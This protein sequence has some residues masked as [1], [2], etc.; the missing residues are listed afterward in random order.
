MRSRI[1]TLVATL[2]LGA[3]PA[4]A[5][6][7]TKGDWEIGGYGGY[8]WLNEYGTLNP[9]SDLLYGA[10]LGYFMSNHWS[11][12]LSGQRLPTST[13]TVP[14]LDFKINS[15]R[16]N[17]MYNL[18]PGSRF[19]PFITAGVGM[20][21]LDV[22][23]NRSNDFGWNA[24][25]G[26]RIFLT[27]RWNFRA[28]GRFVQTKPDAIAGAGSQANGEA[29]AGLS[30]LFGG[31]ESEPVEPPPANQE[32]QV[33]CVADRNEVLPGESV[34][35]TATASDPEGDPL[36]Y[37]W[38][39]SAGRVSGE[40]SSATLDFTG[41][42]APAAATVTVTVSDNHGNTATSNCSVRMLEPVRSAESISCLAGGFPRNAARL[43]NVDKA[44]LDDV[45]TRLKADPRAKVVVIGYADEGE[46]SPDRIGK[47]R[48]DAVEDYLEQAG[49]DA[50]RI[51]TRSSGSSKP[52]GADAL[53]NRRVEV[54]FVPEGATG[55]AND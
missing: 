40:G 22:N 35:I 2:V 27:P 25:G 41:A 38:T 44:C 34:R 3:A 18:A 37:G 36:T 30:I 6:G 10:R 48:A 42:S 43:T 50:S 16:F 45:A 31:G 33:S 14:E 21:Q 19:R 15:V 29:M 46:S 20:E 23:E 11:M 51:T 5:G 13:A 24:G 12:E 32:P 9:K 47:Q 1:L 28:E 55:P 7:G 4:F 52:L 17:T 53:A 49:I 39:T 8:G 26:M 54:W